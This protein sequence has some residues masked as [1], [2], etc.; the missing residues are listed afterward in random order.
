MRTE[1]GRILHERGRSLPVSK[2]DIGD[3]GIYAASL[4]AVLRGELEGT[5]ATAKTIMRWTGAG[6]RTV[7]NWLGGST[8]PSGEYLIKLMRHSDAVFTLVL[9]L[10]ER[11]RVDDPNDMALARRHLLDALAAL[12]GAIGRAN[13]ASNGTTTVVG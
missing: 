13:V 3:G 12:E 9:Q 1:K 5:R 11:T 6:E 8:G 4:A 10:S 7:K 2:G